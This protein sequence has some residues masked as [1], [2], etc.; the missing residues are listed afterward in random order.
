MQI[1]RTANAGVLLT[2]DDASILLD[3]VCQEVSPYLATPAEI[4]QELM[5]CPPDAVLFSHHHEDHFDPDYCLAANKPIYSTVQVAGILPGLVRLEKTCSVGKIKITAV[6]TRHMGH[7]SKT[8]Q[9]CSFVIQGSQTVWFL[10]DASPTELKQLSDFSKPD[11]LIVPYPYI[12][13]PA[14]LKNVLELLP[15]KI[16]LLH[17][18]LREIDPDGIWNSITDGIESL[19][20][21]LY[22]PELGETLNL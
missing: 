13:T 20:A 8:T 19:K 16:V 5:C 21:N 15:C 2:L 14:A 4:R 12:G 17:M 7:Y 10:G 3:G 1:R 18:P 9:H 22:L 11:V 6:P